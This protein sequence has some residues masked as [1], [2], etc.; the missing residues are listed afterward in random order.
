[1]G[2]INSFVQIKSKVN[3]CQYSLHS[4]KHR[5][6]RLMI[7]V[8][9]AAKHNLVANPGCFFRFFM[10]NIQFISENMSGLLNSFGTESDEKHKD[11][12]IQSPSGR[13]PSC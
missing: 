8:C 1:M 2:S 4:V 12:Q 6:L 10:L 11:E 5:G 7:D 9:Q 3:A 13:R